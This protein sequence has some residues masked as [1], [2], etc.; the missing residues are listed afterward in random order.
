MKKIICVFLATV[1]LLGILSACNRKQTQADAWVDNVFENEPTVN[2]QPQNQETIKATEGQPD[3]TTQPTQDQQDPTTQPTQGQQTPTTQPTEPSATDP[4]SPTT[5]N[6]SEPTE[7]EILANEYKAY[8][9]M[10]ADQK[11]NYRNT[12]ANYDAF[13]AW[14]NTA[15]DAYN[16]V[17]P[18]T[19][20]GPDGVIDLS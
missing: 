17:N 10:T 5:G 2:T 6:T 16:K 7:L 4:T 3:P 13:F 19:P 1:L 9:A 15:M 12:F 18:P 20:I 8:Q 11:K 14:Y